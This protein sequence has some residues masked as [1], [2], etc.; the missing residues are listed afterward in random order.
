M[1]THEH[2]RASTRRKILDAAAELFLKK[3]FENTTIMQIVERAD[4]VKGTF[5]QHFQT[6]MDLLLELGREGSAERVRMLIAEV[7]NGRSALDALEGYYR[8]LAQ[9][10]EAHPAIA[11]EVIVSAIRMHDPGSSTPESVAHDFTRLMLQIA[12]RRGEVRADVDVTSQAI[13]IGGAFTLAVIDWSRKPAAAILQRRFG[14]C[15]RVFLQGA[16][17]SGTKP[18]TKNGGFRTQE[19]NA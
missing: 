2:R 10:F 11:E 3:G 15:Y 12:R 6:K 9:W 13:V 4:I 1:A 19:K 17:P 16:I 5:Y 8:V 7:R 14:A 18:P